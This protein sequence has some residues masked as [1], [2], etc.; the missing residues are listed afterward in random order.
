[1]RVSLSAEDGG[2]AFGSD[3][4]TGV[5][6]GFGEGGDFEILDEDDGTV[7]YCWPMLDIT[8]KGS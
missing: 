7:H 6:L 3:I 2:S 8:T 4:V 1:V 5:L